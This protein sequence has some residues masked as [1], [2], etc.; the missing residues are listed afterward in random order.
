[1]YTLTKDYL[2]M[3]NLL[4]TLLGLILDKLK[5]IDIRL[6]ALEAGEVAETTE[7]ATTAAEM[8]KLLDSV[9]ESAD[10]PPV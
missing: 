8:Q 7:E 5:T 4:A 2:P 6:N 10:V 3:L 1:M 9:R